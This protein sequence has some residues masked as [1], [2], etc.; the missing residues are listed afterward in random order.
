M[1][2]LQR[3]QGGECV[4][5]KIIL[6]KLIGNNDFMLRAAYMRVAS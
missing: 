5:N 2:T 4:E 1:F 6:S 3:D